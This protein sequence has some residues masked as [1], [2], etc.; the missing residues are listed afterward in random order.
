MPELTLASE[1]LVLTLPQA[2]HAGAMLAFWQKN[3]DFLS[4]WNP[5]PNGDMHSLEY[6]QDNIE[7]AQVGF[8]AGSQLRLLMILRA[9]P[10]VM[11]G[12]I[13]YSQIFRGPFRSCMLGY[14]I[15]EAEQGRGL[16]R[17]ALQTSLRHVFEQL[18][19]HRVGAN[20]MPHNV[21]SGRLLAGLGFR[22][23]GYAKNYLFIGDAWRDHV[24]TSLVND[25]F[26]PQWLRG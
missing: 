10:D 3:S 23:E 20:Y 2:E 9:R 22:I 25:A 24:L 5:P 17:E 13:G 12:S 19:L 26:R 7:K 21:K 8:L 11:I 4:P 16:M 18:R 6:W 15:D 14:Q 1:R